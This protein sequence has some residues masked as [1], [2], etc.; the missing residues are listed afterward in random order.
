MNARKVI[1]AAAAFAVAA[2]VGFAFGFAAVGRAA[3]TLA[4]DW[5]DHDAIAE[6]VDG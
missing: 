3:H 4:S 5:T 2:G 1:G 6:L